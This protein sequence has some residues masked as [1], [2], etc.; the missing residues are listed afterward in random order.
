[1]KQDYATA[2]TC[3]Y[4]LFRAETSKEE[5]IKR[6][7]DESVLQS[8]RI[9]SVKHEGNI[10]RAVVRLTFGPSEKL[11]RKEPA[12]TTVIIDLIKENGEWKIKV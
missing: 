11:K 6:W 1:M 8:Y 2:Y 3:Y 7:K 5:Y 10:A 4:T 12:A 9:T